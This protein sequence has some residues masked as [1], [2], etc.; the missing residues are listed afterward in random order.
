MSREGGFRAF[1]VNV[2]EVFDDAHVYATLQYREVLERY[3]QRLDRNP[4]DGPARI[5]LARTLIKCGL[6]HDAI[7]ELHVARQDPRARDK[8]FHELAVASFRAGRYTDAGLFARDAMALTGSHPRSRLILWL[9][10]QKAG[11]YA[12]DVPAE[13]RMQLRSGQQPTNLA[14]V[15]VAAEIGLDKTSGGRGTAIFDYDG[16]GYLDVLVAAAHGGCT[17]YKNNGDGTFT[18]ASISSGMDTLSHRVRADVGDYDNDGVPDVFV[19]RNGFFS[20]ACS[21]YHNNGDGTF[22]DVTAKSGI[23]GLGTGVHGVVGRLRLRRQARSLRRLQ[24]RIALRAQDAQSPVPQQRGRYVHRR[25]RPAAGITSEWP[26]I[27]H[28][29]GDY[30]N[31]GRPDLFVSNSLGRSQLFHNNGD[32]TFTDVSRE[33]GVDSYGLGSICYFIDYRQR[34]LARYRPERVVGLRRRHPHDAERSR[35][36]RMVRRSRC[37]ATIATARFR[38]AAASLASP[39]AGAA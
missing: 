39:A 34:R 21:L 1:I 17:L 31:D 2:L 25:D 29:W 5:E 11:G 33:A 26:T 32:G 37:G 27:G 13:M 20:G 4:G 38:C 9:A 23:T 3:K 12:P 22:T 14:L 15:D 6:Y 16:D 35:V 7:K 28:A 24:P 30:D 36:R 18:D 19:T 8:A 10:A